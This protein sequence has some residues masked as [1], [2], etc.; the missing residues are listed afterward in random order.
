MIVEKKITIIKGEEGIFKGR[1]WWIIVNDEKS[2]TNEERIILKILNG[3]KDLEEGEK[4]E[5]K[6]QNATYELSK[7]ANVTV[8][9]AIEEIR[10]APVLHTKECE[11][12][13]MPTVVKDFLGV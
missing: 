5:I 12:D 6:K 10:T 11:V 9:N 3:G 13:E 2:L 7:L 8:P 4:I 1:Q